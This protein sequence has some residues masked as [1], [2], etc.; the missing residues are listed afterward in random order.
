[1]SLYDRIFRPRRYTLSDGT[2][3]EEKR[4]RAPLVI[5]ILVVLT[6]VS[7]RITGFNF[8]VLVKKGSKFF[9]ILK[10]MFP[11][12]TAYLGKIWQPLWDT[13]KMSFLGSF[14]G[15]VLAIPFAIAAASNIVTNRVVV[16]LVR[17]FLSLVRTLPTLV[18]ALIA[19]YIFGLG[20][21][22]GT[23]AIAVFTFAYVGKQL[24]EII[25]TVDMGPYE[26][27]EAL[28]AT[29]LRAFVTA[30]FPQVLPTYLSVSLFC[31]NS[32]IGK[33][34]IKMQTFRIIAKNPSHEN[35]ASKLVPAAVRFFVLAKFV[36]SKQHSALLYETAVLLFF[37]VINAQMR[38]DIISSCRQRFSSF[39]LAALV[40][41]RQRGTSLL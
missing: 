14:I 19:T 9:D 36:R 13:I 8:S 38:D 10:A 32:S 20:T 7:V 34:R 28:G 2:V 21:M 31:Y 33:T 22:A 39:L 23:C 4:S 25:E 30:V 16:F 12:N 5:L 3:V 24:F 26:A 27:L 35:A 6:A 17:L 18:C 11:P 29:R 15:A 1:M 40:R 37:A 41:S